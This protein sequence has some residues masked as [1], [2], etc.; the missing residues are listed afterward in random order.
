[1]D[2]RRERVAQRL[3]ELRRRT[4]HI[5]IFLQDGC[6]ARVVET[7]LRVQQLVLR[8]R[9]EH[10]NEYPCSS[11]FSRAVFAPGGRA[12]A[13]WLVQQLT[14][15]GVTVTTETFPVHDVRDL[16]ATP[17]LR[18]RGQDLVHRR[19]F[20]EH[21]ASADLPEPARS[22]SRTHWCPGVPTPRA[23]CRR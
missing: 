17:T 16:Y 18:W 3:F 6:R 8:Q 12:A 13:Q 23:G 9:G 4:G 15:L 14:Q 19:D 5:V 10:T 22:P 20:V 21:L 2:D 11:R 1:M 7:T